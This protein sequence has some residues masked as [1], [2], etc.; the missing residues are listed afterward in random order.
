MIGP[1]PKDMTGAQ[2]S[3]HFSLA[4]TVVKG[5]NDFGTYL[6]ASSTG[7]R[8]PDTLRVAKDGARRAL[9]PECDAV[10]PDRWLAKV[11]VT[12][13]DGRRFTSQALGKPIV[14]K[15]KVEAK[16]RT[17]ARRVM[18]ESQAENILLTVNRLEEATTVTALTGLLRTED[19]GLLR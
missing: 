18:P 3:S 2:F 17:L 10:F 11:A 5:G 4:L 7:F 19:A 9:D 6:D 15:A 8:D 1:E 13:K 16:F 12:T 14:S